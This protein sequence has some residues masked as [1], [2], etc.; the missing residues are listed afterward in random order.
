MIRVVVVD[1]DVACTDTL[2]QLLEIEGFQI[3]GKGY[4]G[5]E[6]YELYK[7][8]KPDVIILDMKMPE[9]D[10]NYAIDHI[11]K[12]FPDAVIIVVTAFKGDYHLEQGVSGVFSKPYDI[13]TLITYI[14]NVTQERL[15]QK[16]Q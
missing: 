8:H 12:E 5:K 13:R 1:D 11:K 3:L 6:G 9:Y 2:S 4:N 14:R 10:G 15:I 16:E 7:Q